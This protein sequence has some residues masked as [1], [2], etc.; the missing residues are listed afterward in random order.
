MLNGAVEEL[1]SAVEELNSAVE[2]LI[3]AVEEL[4]SAT[5]K[6]PS[7]RPHRVKRRQFRVGD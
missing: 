3:S 7:I 2:E 6:T 1:I 4:I 5:V